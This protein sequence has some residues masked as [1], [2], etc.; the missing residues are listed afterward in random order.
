[1]HTA[2]LPIDWMQVS[3]TC[4]LQNKSAGEHQASLEKAKT[5]AMQCMQKFLLNF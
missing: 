2:G 3:A 1:V 5:I 4:M